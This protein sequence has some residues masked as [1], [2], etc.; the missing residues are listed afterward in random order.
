MAEAF[1]ASE[2]EQRYSFLDDCP[3]QFLQEIVT[4]PVGTLQ[5]RV[6]GIRAWREALLVTLSSQI[7]TRKGRPVHGG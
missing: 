6:R 5:E 4:L 2:L 3:D 7:S 1:D